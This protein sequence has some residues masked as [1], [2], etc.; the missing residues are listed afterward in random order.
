MKSFPFT[1][2]S[3]HHPLPAFSLQRSGSIPEALR[4]ADLSQDMRK[5]LRCLQAVQGQV[6]GTDAARR[7]MRGE[8]ASLTTYFGYPLLLDRK[9]VV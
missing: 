2:F 3:F 4:A 9:S 6:P 7:I 1:F 8:L 5:I